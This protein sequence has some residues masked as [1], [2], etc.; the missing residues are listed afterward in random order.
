[1]GNLTLE[2]YTD[3]DYVG[4]IIDRRS[5]S[6]Y[7]TFFEGNL[8]TWR[9]KKQNV[10]ARSS[11]EVEFR[12]MA[13]R[14]CCPIILPRESE[15]VL[16]GAAILGAVAAKKYTCLNEAMKVLNA[17]GQVIHPSTDPRVKKYHDAKYR[18][19][20]ELYEQQLSQR[21]IMAQALA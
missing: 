17:A 10:V 18:I 19:F 6:G 21:S 2:A 16:L 8:V 9:N 13:L 15:S 3:A 20:L 1:M 5:T 7:C 11:A 4:S 14:I 12:A